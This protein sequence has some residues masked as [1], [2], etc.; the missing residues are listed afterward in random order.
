MDVDL[1]VAL[2]DGL[3]VVGVG[4]DGDV[5]GIDGGVGMEGGRGGFGH[6]LVGEGEGDGVS[7]LRFGE[8]E[9]VESR[10]LGCGRSW[11]TTRC[12]E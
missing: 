2:L 4:W 3:V 10:I 9:R 1:A 8:V 6:F 12:Q 7:R 11:N 5:V